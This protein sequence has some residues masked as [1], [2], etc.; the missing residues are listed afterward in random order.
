MFTS[1]LAATDRITG[2]DPVIISAARMARALGASWSIVHVLESASLENRE[3]VLHFHTGQV[4]DATASYRAEIRRQLRRAYNDLFAWAPPCEIRIATGFPWKEID[5]QASLLAADLII[6]GPHAGDDDKRGVLRVRDRIGSTVKDMITRQRCPVLMVNQHPCR[7]KPA[8]KRLLVGMD[9]SAS[10]ECALGFAADLARFYQAHIDLFHMLPIPPYPKYAR[11]DYDADR[12]SALDKMA[13][14]SKPYI[15]G[16]SHSFHCWGGAIPYQELCKCVGNCQTDAIVIG[17]HTKETQ[18]KWYAG[19]TVE[20]IGLRTTCPVFV[21]THSR[22]L[23][24]WGKSSRHS[25]SSASTTDHMIH[26]FEKKRTK[27]TS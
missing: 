19:S 10:C 26:I 14:F 4:Q 24:R 9:F 16:V 1:I 11:N 17:S 27:M 5:R 18:G 7:P 20:K 12:E 6:M 25:T 8:F 21:L 23:T 13:L 3:R 22:A 15:A 2:R